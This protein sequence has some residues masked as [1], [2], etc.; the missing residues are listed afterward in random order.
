MVLKVYVGDRNISDISLTNG[1]K[2]FASWKDTFG[3]AY[4]VVGENGNRMGRLD[5]GTY[6][7]TAS[8]GDETMPSYVDLTGATY[9]VL[10]FN[11][12]AHSAMVKLQM[13]GTQTVKV[14]LPFEP[15]TVTSSNPNLIIQDWSYADGFLQMSVKGIRL[16]GE[17]GT[18]T[19]T[20]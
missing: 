1:A 2:V 4:I 14:K 7:M 16:T 13:Y 5:P 17:V 8:F 3:Y 12:G 9:N 19:M 6:Q 20:G 15:T 11:A 18:I 10:G